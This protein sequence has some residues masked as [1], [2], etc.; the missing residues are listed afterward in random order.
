MVFDD[1]SLKCQMD[2]LLL[3]LLEL[4]LCLVPLA[5]CLSELGLQA[6]LRTE[7]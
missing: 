7:G 1:A 5:S 3:L 6:C 4:A 2:L